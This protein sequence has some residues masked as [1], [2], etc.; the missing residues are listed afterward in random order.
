M[1]TLKFTR[2]FAQK[3]DD[4]KEVRYL[5]GKTYSVADEVAEAALK[6][7]AA[8]EVLAVP[9]APAKKDG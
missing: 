8:E 6:A 3:L 9:K 1:K 5:E 4:R 7:G 2:Q